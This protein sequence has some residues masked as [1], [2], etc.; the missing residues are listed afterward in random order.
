[1]KVTTRPCRSCSARI[2]W[3]VTSRGR[4]MPVDAEPHPDGDIRLIPRMGLTTPRAEVVTKPRPGEQLRHLHADPSSAAPAGR[5]E[6][7]GQPTGT[8]PECT[9]CGITDDRA[10]R[11]RED[12]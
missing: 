5:C 7:C 6:V 2:V 3:A 1:M 8:P 4:P 11:R 12:V 10:A 9:A